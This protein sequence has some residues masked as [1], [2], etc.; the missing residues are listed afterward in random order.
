M[1][2]FHT[3]RVHIVFSKKK[4][5][6]R[7]YVEHYNADLNTTHGRDCV[8]WTACI[9]TKALNRNSYVPNLYRNDDERRLDR[10]RWDDEWNDKNRFL[11]VR[12][13]IS[14]HRGDHEVVAPILSF[15][16]LTQVA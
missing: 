14:L 2:E 12:N 4:S 13:L 11:C 10:N 7:V 8:W 5:T 9:Y 16:L 15:A 6:W 1:Y 3:C